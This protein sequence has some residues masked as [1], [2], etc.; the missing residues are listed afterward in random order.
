MDQARAYRAT[1]TEPNHA[2]EAGVLIV[3]RALAAAAT[4]TDE[5]DVL[6]ELAAASVPYGS[7]TQQGPK[8]AAG[9]VPVR[10]R[11]MAAVAGR[12]FV[13]V[14]I[15]FEADQSR[16]AAHLPATASPQRAAAVRVRAEVLRGL[17]ATSR[18]RHSGN[19]RAAV[20]GANDGLVS[21][22]A[23]VVGMSAT[24]VSAGVVLAA[25]MAGLLAG[26]LS[27]AAGEYISVRSARELL[28]ASRLDPGSVRGLSD[29][30]ADVE[31]IAL[32]YQARGASRAQ[33]RRKAVR[34]NGTDEQPAPAAAP[35]AN[36]SGARDMV[37]QAWGAAISSFF[38]FAS[39][40]LIP[41][42]PYLMGWGATAAITSAVLLVGAAL[43]ATG[44][45]VGLLSGASALRRAFRQLAIGYGA[46]AATYLLGLL[47]GAVG[48]G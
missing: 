32:I 29:T 3:L 46:A 7:R 24:G 11:M 5:R 21:N 31:Q 2:A 16:A 14:L 25:G 38:F 45:T 43:L 41:I 15:A 9:S 10:Y 42:L 22:L 28:Q 6:L 13:P 48:V 47:F 23:L 19:F 12:A 1:Q 26:A 27:M 36:E 39:G 34:I 44:A 33:A 30:G 37:G 17:A 35:A 20:F 40:A 18:E 8:P 4:R